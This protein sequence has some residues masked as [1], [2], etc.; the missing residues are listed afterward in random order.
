MRIGIDLGGTKIEGLALADDGRAL[1]RRRIAA[2]RGNYDDTVRAVTHR[3][4]QR[5]AGADRDRQQGAGQAG[6]TVQRTQTHVDGE[7]ADEHTGQRRATEDQYRHQRDAGRREER[8]R[9]GCRAGQEQGGAADCG[10]SQRGRA[11][12]DGRAGPIGDRI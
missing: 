3:S 10:V 7:R 9:V 2:P 1:D 11:D 4:L 8:R 5:G 6:L 12:G